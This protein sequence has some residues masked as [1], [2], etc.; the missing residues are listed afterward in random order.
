MHIPDGFIGPGVSAATGLAALGTF[1]VAIRKARNYLTDRLVPMAS[2]VAAFVFAAQM[3]NFPVIP[4]M[5]GHLLG[6]VLAAVLVGPWAGLIVM[7]IVLVVQAFLFADGGLS[8]LGLNMVNMGLIGAIGGYLVYRVVLEVLG[9]RNARVAPAAGIAALISVPMAALGFF[10]EF[11]IG[12]TVDSISLTSVFWAIVATHLLIGV[13]EGLI[14][15]LVVG[16]VIGSRP[17]LVYGAPSFAGQRT[18]ELVA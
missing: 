2:L 3:I 15:F 1:G 14:T 4:G 13:G 12:G 9:S 6:G 18:E 7:T 11:A 16:A 8:A 17:D 10:L 5:S